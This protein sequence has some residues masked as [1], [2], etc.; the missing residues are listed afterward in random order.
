MCWFY[1]NEEQK[2]TQI[3]T[4]VSTPVIAPGSPTQQ[5]ILSTLFLLG[6]EKTTKFFLCYSRS[7][8]QKIWILMYM[9]YS[10]REVTCVWIQQVAY[11]L[12]VHEELSRVT[13]FIGLSVS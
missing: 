3:T 8:K 7:R 4:K 10:E 6:T 12:P 9:W 1:F 13:N 11:K 5:E 2:R